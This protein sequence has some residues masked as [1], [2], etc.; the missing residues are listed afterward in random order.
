LFGLAN[1]IGSIESTASGQADAKPGGPLPL[2]RYFPRQDLVVYAEFDGL[3][4]H[5]D[6][7]TRTAAYR[8]LNETTTAELYEKSVSR[9]LDLVLSKQSGAPLNGREAVT[10]AMHVLR[11]G[12]AVG[13]NRAGGSGPPRSFA[14]VLRA[15]AKG[16]PG[17]IVDRLLRAGASPRGRVEQV[18]RPD[19][20]IVQVMTDSTPGHLAWWAEG[21]DL[22]V[23]L[24]SASGPDAIIA[25]LE[26]R[27]P[28]AVEHPIRAALARGDRGNGFLPVGVGFFDMAAL[29]S[30][31][32]EAAALGLD[33]IKHFE[34]RWGFREAV[35]ESSVGMVAPSPRRGIPALFDQPALDVRDLPPLPGGLAGFTV[36][37]LDP[38]RFWDSLR[39]SVAAVAVEPGRA[40]FDG[41]DQIERVFQAATGLRLRE[42]VLVNLGSRWTFYNVPTRANAPSNILEGLAQGFFRVPKM[43]FVIEVKNRDAM[44]R[45]LSRFVL[46]ARD[47]LRNE[48]RQSMPFSVGEIRLLRG[49]SAGFLFSLNGRELPFSA[50]LWPTV[51]LGQ[52]A[53]VIASSPAMARAARDL[54][55]RRGPGGLPARDPL[56]G[57]L[58][59][60]PAGLTLLSVGDP[61]QSII[62]EIIVGLPALVESLLKGEGFRRL[63]ILRRF[64]IED[65]GP[66]T[67]MPEGIVD[68][69]L[70]PDPDTLR[71]FF[72][73]SIH[74]LAV[75]DQGIRYVSR[76]AVP[77]INPATAVPVAIAMLVPAARSAQIA[78]RRA[79]SVNNLKQI[80]LAMHN[81]LSSNGQFPADIRS[82]DGKPLLS[83]RVQILPFIDQAALFNE[84]RLDEP[85][86]SPHNKAL[87]ER[88]P[89]TFAVPGR[90][91]EPGSTFYR[92]FKGTN[93]IFDP[94]VPKG[95]TI[96]SIT[97]GT[98]NTIAVVEAKQAVPWTKPDSDLRFD[99][100][101]KLERT[102]A[103][104]SELGGHFTGG[105]NALFCDGSVRFIRVTVSLQVLQS[106]I[107][108]NGGEVISSDSF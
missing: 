55:E 19:G 68:P 13:I 31:P 21:D 103:L 102:K 30:L 2:A 63:P 75:N 93:T 39:K 61:R 56:A 82:K 32:K 29:P 41:A 35:L 105:F 81:F 94:L 52:K 74:A 83:W 49:E 107:T 42:D 34:Y 40:E 97:D 27:E 24:V 77:T 89:A 51:L 54:S 3:D 72:F 10:L 1:A 64:G 67:P 6:A 100:D 90:P 58:A 5:R 20:R 47:T 69:E 78:A 70:I 17:A 92:G 71:P 62:P 91:G 76:E 80:G 46:R 28:N 108:R 53:L 57:T 88:M 36:L 14:M 15:A 38:T 50:G 84:V 65:G 48:P 33:G 25:A 45:S 4:A 85:W 60:L 101:P 16:E 8:L 95:V 43:A 9:L 79:Q 96:Q 7:W 66:P 26:N 99:H 12:F 11:A 104:L 37:S 23:S 22:V 73:P 98:S 18:N 106:L 87:L 59:S 86:D 44:A